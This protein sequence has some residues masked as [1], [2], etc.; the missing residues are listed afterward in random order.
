MYEKISLHFSKKLL[1]N[2]IILY[3]N[4]MFIKKYISIIAKK[5]NWQ[6]RYDIFNMVFLHKTHINC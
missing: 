6:I 4:D 3:A 2:K 5:Q 1:V